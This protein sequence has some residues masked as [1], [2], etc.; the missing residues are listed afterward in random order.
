MYN[1]VATKNISKEYLVNI[2]T[3]LFAKIIQKFAMFER[4]FDFFYRTPH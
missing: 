2:P 1:D 4:P 3:T